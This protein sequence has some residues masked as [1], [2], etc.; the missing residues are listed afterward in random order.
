MAQA[1]RRAFPH[2]DVECVDLLT[3]VPAWLRRSYPSIY[4]LLVR[5]CSTLW[6]AGFAALDRPLV[7]GIAQPIRRLWN[8]V[9]ARRF[10]RWV[11]QTTPQLIV[12][13]HFF[14]ADLLSSCKQSGEVSSRLAVIVTDLHP[15]RFWL[16]PGADAY[17]VSTDAAAAAAQRC[18]IPA[19]RLHTLGIP[20]ADSFRAAFDRR[21]LEE[22]FG[23]HAGRFTVLMTSG[24]ST[25]GPFEAVTMALM[26]LEGAVPGRLQLVVVC[27]H[28]DAMVRRLRAHA[29]HCRMPVR[30]FGFIDT[31]PE[32][33]AVSDLVVTKAGGLTVTEALARGLPLVIY[34]VIPGQ[35]RENAEHVVSHGAGVIATAPHAVAQM[36]RRCVTDVEYV[37]S[38]RRAA[39]TLSRP[40]AAARI[41]EQVV[42][43]LLGGSS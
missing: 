28:N 4:Y 32:V 38:L 7:S 1:I 26:Q 22:R 10:V 11:R 2:T 35:E 37:A 15:H 43:P 20:I 27:G 25:I 33:M 24:G 3:F 30:V 31:M 21:E 8:R 18:G 19:E 36:V 34:H 6:G 16:A 12:T 39:Q 9:M 23:L 42:T 14:P 13:T 17:I 29:Q 41:V 5:H 40:D